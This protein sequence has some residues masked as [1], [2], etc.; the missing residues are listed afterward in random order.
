MLDK[1]LLDQLKALIDDRVTENI[2]L[3]SSL[4]DRPKS[5]DMKEM[6]DEVAALS[7]KITHE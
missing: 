7:D 6:L 4:D 5:A 2:V 3:A 1:D